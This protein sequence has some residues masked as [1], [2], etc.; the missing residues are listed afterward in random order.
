MQFKDMDVSIKNYIFFTRKCIL[1]TYIPTYITK[2]IKI[3]RVIN[4]ISQFEAKNRFQG[5]FPVSIFLILR[6]DFGLAF[7][8]RKRN[9]F[10]NP[11]ESFTRL[12]LEWFLSTKYLLKIKL[13]ICF[14]FLLHFII[15]NIGQ[16]CVVE[17]KIWQT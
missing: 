9:F 17:N 10:F 14:L 4:E 5:F 15:I 11:P 8:L 13:V 12:L 6:S 3:D 16:I 1:S 2:N 7:E